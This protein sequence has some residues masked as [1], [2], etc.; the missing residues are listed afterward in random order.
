[1]VIAFRN[2]VRLQ[3]LPIPTRLRAKV[4]VKL[5][6]AR[7]VSIAAIGPAGGQSVINSF[8]LT[9]SAGTDRPE[10]TTDEV[11]LAIAQCMQSHCE[12]KAS[13]DADIAIAEGILF[14]VDFVRWKGAPGAA[15]TSFQW[16]WKFLETAED[17]GAED[18]SDEAAHGENSHAYL[19]SMI[20]LLSDQAER[21][22]QQ[23][24]DATQRLVTMAERMSAPLRT[25][26][27]QL[28]FSNSI[29]T[30]GMHA[31]VH[32]MQVRYS[33]E[34]SKELEERKSERMDKLLSTL[35]PAINI[36]IAQ[37]SHALGN[38]MSGG[39][40]SSP[41]AQEMKK[42][43]MK[44]PQKPKANVDAQPPN[45]DDLEQA[46]DALAVA[47]QEFGQTLTPEDWAAVKESFSADA[48]AA[49]IALLRSKTDAQALKAYG[50]LR[51]HLPDLGSVL[52]FSQKLSET[53]RA[54]VMNLV[55]LLEQAQAT[56]H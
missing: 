8:R 11:C 46:S 1:M 3:D 49:F 39:T 56:K 10:E 27:D 36:G 7:A 12:E 53:P 2:D 26:Q 54:Y 20:K 23:T 14:K 6:Y 32:A 30:Q 25:V 34:A 43:I 28:E 22:A 24:A 47:C 55:M 17:L 21:Q 42:R 52:A 44:Q 38:K 51:S 33:F 5:P 41:R 40:M 29:M 31:M 16:R 15:R 19:H 18:D 48:N 37:F 9:E 50:D 13:L 45:E 35:G 4:D